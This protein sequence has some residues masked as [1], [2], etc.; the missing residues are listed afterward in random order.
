MNYLM[1]A[2]MIVAGSLVGIVSSFFGVGAC[3]IMVP[4]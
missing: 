2:T 1:I 3:F 4:V